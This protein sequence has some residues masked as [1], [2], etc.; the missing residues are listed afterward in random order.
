M[1]LLIVEL[2]HRRNGS[3]SSLP[4]WRRWWRPN[5][6][7]LKHPAPRSARAGAANTSSSLSCTIVDTSSFEG[8]EEE[9]GVVIIIIAMLDLVRFIKI[10]IIF[11]NGGEGIIITPPRQ[12]NRDLCWGPIEELTVILN[13]IP[14]EC[15]RKAGQ[16]V[17]V[18]RVPFQFLFLYGE[19]YGARSSTYFFSNEP[20]TTIN[21]MMRKY[22][23]ICW[24]K[25]STVCT[26]PLVVLSFENHNTPEMFMSSFLLLLLTRSII[27]NNTASFL[28]LFFLVAM[29]S[30]F[31]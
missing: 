19:L 14:H 13:F 28:V 11:Y 5:G 12:R 16:F 3:A 8:T 1:H 17:I 27:N 9:C 7:A 10:I 23:S 18:V 21:N 4:S 22:T 6:V 31:I 30:L 29:T 26:M 24:T 2:L 25:I 15:F 20:G